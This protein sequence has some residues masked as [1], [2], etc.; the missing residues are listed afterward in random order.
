MSG[1]SSVFASWGLVQ[2][3]PAC[4]VCSVCQAFSLCGKAA[5]TCLQLFVAYAELCEDS[6]WPPTWLLVLMLLLCA[7]VLR[8]HRSL[9]GVHGI[10]KVHYKG[11][12][13][14]YYIMVRCASCWVGCRDDA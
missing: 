5:C 2:L 4:S 14:D 6:G 3:L 7:C 8:S 1:S 11:R 13:G 9:G 12:Q 10:P